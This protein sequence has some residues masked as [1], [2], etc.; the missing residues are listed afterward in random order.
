MTKKYLIVAGAMIY[1]CEGTKVRRDHRFNNRYIYSIE[2][3]NSRPETIGLFSKFLKEIFE[4][5]WKRIRGQLF[6]YPD[7][8]K[9]KLISYWSRVSGIPKVQ[10][11]QVI[12]LTQKNSK[13]KPNPL[14]TFKIRYSNKVDFLK[15]QK[16]IDGVWK[17]AGLANI[18]HGRVA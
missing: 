5:D 11:Q 14:G 2:L 18:N 6:L 16:L 1:A 10:F 13:Y 15:L 3:T 8:D 7:H 12:S 4:I 9:E 17:E